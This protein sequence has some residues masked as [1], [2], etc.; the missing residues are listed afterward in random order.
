MPTLLVIGGGHTGK[1]LCEL[2]KWIG[3][4]VVL[5]DD[6]DEFCNPEYIPGLNGYLPVPPGEITQNIE[7]NA[8]TYVAAVTRG[9]PVDK[10][11]LPALLKTDAAYIGLIG[12]RRRWAL[13]RSRN[14]KKTACPARIL[15][16]SMHRWDWNSMP[17]RRRKSR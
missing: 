2:G 17:K 14:W 8:R 13:G 16:A 5:S 4:R 6:R 10:N 12:S 11:L 3:F 9:L 15:N 7:I 1:A